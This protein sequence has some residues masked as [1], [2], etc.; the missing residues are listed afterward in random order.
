[1]HQQGNRPTVVQGFWSGSRLNALQRACLGSFVHHGHRFVLFSYE[2]IEAVDGVVIADAAH[3]VP[4]SKLFF[5]DNPRSGRPDIGPFSD[6][7]RYRLL[8]QRGGWYCDVDTL[9]LSRKLPEG[10]RIWARQCPGVDPDS[11]AN[12]QMFME[13]GDPLAGLLVE[14]CEALI[15]HFTV[16][17]ALG[18]M[19]LSST[20]K[21]CG[22]PLDFGASA[23]EFYPIQWIEVFKL[24]LP[25]HRD[26]VANR[27]ESAIFVPLYQS[28]PTYVGLDPRFGPPAGSYLDDVVRRFLSTD[29]TPRHLAEDVRACVQRWFRARGKWALD[30]LEAIDGAGAASLV[31]L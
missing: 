21:E 26:E 5:F 4:R 25:E 6:Y 10:A 3:I 12:G 17:E 31:G 22:L 14:R 27:V 29:T 8:H 20:L 11:V 7:F 18:P 9:C 30:W 13:A 23:A 15:P 28:F 16:R 1:M 19:L 2:S 24:W